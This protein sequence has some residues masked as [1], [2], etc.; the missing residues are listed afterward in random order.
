MKKNKNRYRLLFLSVVLT[1]IWIIAAY[2]LVEIQV[3]HGKEYSEKA[4]KQSSGKIK[5]PADRGLIYDRQGRQLAIN[6]SRN[7]LYA[8]PAD[9]REI[10]KIFSYLDKLYNRPAGKS[11][12]KYRLKPNRFC[13]LDRDMEDRLAQKLVRDSIPGLYLKKE[14]KRNYPMASVGCQLLGRTDIDGNG[15]SGVEFSYDSV[16][17]G[18]PGLIDYLRDAHRN[19]YNIKELPLIKPVGGNSIVLTID[20]YF[21]EIVEEELRAAVVEYNA[22]EGSAVFMDCRTGEILAAADYVAGGKS[23]MV[24][25]R[26]VSNCFE[27]GSVFKVFTAAALLEE[28]LIDFDEKI[29]CENGVWQIGRRRLHDDKDRDSLVFREIFELSSNIGIAKM[30]IKLGGQRLYENAGRFGFGAKCLVNLPGEQSGNIAVPKVWSDYNTAALAIG[31]AVSATPLQLAAAVSSVANGGQLYRPFLMRGIINS[32]GELIKRFKPELIA[33]V[34]DHTIADSLRAFMTGVVERGTATPVKSEYV[35]IGGKTGTAQVPDLENGGYLRGKYNASFLGFFPANNP[36]LAGIVVLYQPE[37][38]HYGGHT[39]GP[40]FKKMAERYTLANMER[41]NPETSLPTAADHLKMIEIPDFVDMEILLAQKI[42]A[43]KGLKLTTNADVGIIVWQY[44]PEGRRLPGSDY[45]AVIVSN[46]SEESKTMLDL[47][48]LNVRTATA[49]L[50]QQRVKFE[51][52]G[53]GLI[54]KQTPRPGE[55]IS[56]RTVCRLLGTS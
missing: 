31:H 14:V 8:Y 56:E 20:Y 4:E 53:G 49:V 18:S 25:L 27:P 15:I 10:K 9:K 17:A 26:A 43:K 12:K 32:D 39:A 1:L 19:L 30:A 50:N 54:K 28:G 36:I 45:V 13:W 51:I 23:D 37:P 38:V 34:I 42:V 21:Q 33:P 52:N 47:T 24:K 11:K 48:G 40:A 16:L 22:L 29:D 5:V 55:K 44:P 3:V 6:V 35:S 41:C 46:D 2:R 7:A